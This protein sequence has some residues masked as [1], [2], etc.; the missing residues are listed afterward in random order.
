VSAP[1]DGITVLSIEQAV[2]APFAT[3]QLADLGARV[4]KIERP[5]EGDFARG[6]DTAVHGESSYFVWLN[7]G[8]ESVELDLKSPDGQ[9][10]VEALLGRA[11]VF[12]QNLAPG[13]AARLGWG[14]E[15]LRERHPSLI[16]CAISGYGTGSSWSSRKAYDLLIQCETGLVSL[17]GTPEETARVGVSIADIATGM[18]AYSG[19][20]AALYTRTTTGRAHAVEVSLFDALTEWMSQPAYYTRYGGAPPRRLGVRHA[21]IAPYGAYTA[22]DGREVLLTVQSE[23][24]WVLLCEEILDMPGL[25]IDG[26]FTSSARRVARRDE[27]DRIIARQL[28]DID[29]ADLVDKLERAGIAYAR[30][31]DVP[32]FL[33]HPVLSERERWQPIGTPVGRVEAFLPPVQL[34]GVVPRMGDIPRLGQHTQSV[35]DELDLAQTRG[36]A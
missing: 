36:R 23:R 25:A 5:G 1:L 18:Y 8:K 21:T 4:I 15:T 16:T 10:A 29:S 24:E 28:G 19:I 27:L 34:D 3:R 13:A 17:T 20:L 7:R 30:I 33:T 32:A 14:T 11:D 6:Y 26:R 2:A 31:N 12:V 9:A 22:R 35:L